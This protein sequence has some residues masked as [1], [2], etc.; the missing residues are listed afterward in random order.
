MLSREVRWT[1]AWLQVALA[2]TYMALHS[3]AA[4]SLGT[5]GCRDAISLFLRSRA[6]AGVR[7]VRSGGQL[8]PLGFVLTAG[9]T[10]VVSWR[11]FRDRIRCAATRGP[12]GHRR[13]ARSS[14]ASVLGSRLTIGTAAG[15]SR[16]GL[17]PDAP[18]GAAAAPLCVAAAVSSSVGAV[19]ISNH[20]GPPCHTAM[21]SHVPLVC[22][23]CW[24]WCMLAL[25][26][27]CRPAP[28]GAA[29]PQQQPQPAQAAA[30]KQAPRSSS[31]CSRP[32]G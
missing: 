15:L 26:P 4:A 17:I 31:R 6:G 22:C 27:P 14:A 10:A 9:P 1:V 16:V 12:A 18:L 30:A 13:A 32:A 25:P 24:G 23:C 20:A 28:C 21:H 2:A 8:R 11:P 7:Q 19:T 5:Q 29:P 3:P